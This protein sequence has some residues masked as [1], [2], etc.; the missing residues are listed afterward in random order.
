MK[1]SRENS[2]RKNITSLV[3]ASLFAALIS[4]GTFLAIPFAPV[5]LVMQN[6]F[7][8]LSG[9]VL[10]PV[11]GAASV[12]LFVVAGA[13]GAPVFAGG[14]AGLAVLLGPTGGFLPGYIIGAFVAGLIAGRPVPGI[15]TPVWKIGVAVAAGFLAVYVPGLFRLRH[16]TESWQQAFIVGFFPFIAGDAVKGIIAVIVA[17]RLR[18]TATQLLSR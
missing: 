15:K 16:F 11:P 14:K 6:M 12:G 3:F 18:S 1:E 5:P 2:R 8:I 4:A 13:L 17:G 10:G 7:A 9:I